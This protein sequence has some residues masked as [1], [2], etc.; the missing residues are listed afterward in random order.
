MTMMTRTTVRMSR[1]PQKTGMA[2]MRGVTSA[3]TG[4]TAATSNDFEYSDVM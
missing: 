3:E 2:N 4:F 1:I